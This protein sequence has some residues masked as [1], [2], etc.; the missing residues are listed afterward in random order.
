M[1]ADEGPGQRPSTAM[2]LHC[3]EMMYADPLA[4]LLWES[5]RLARSGTAA[6]PC[7]EKARK[8]MRSFKCACTSD[9]ILNDITRG[10]VNE[11]GSWP[12]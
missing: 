4:S 8:G 9:V 7:L 12:P 6:A 5:P 2:Q 1:H 3:S 11:S 10:T